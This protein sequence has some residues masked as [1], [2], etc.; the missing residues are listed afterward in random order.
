[1]SSTT[2]RP[3]VT[4]QAVALWAPRLL[5]VLRIVSGLMFMAHG[6]Q[7]LLGFP[8]PAPF[9][10]PA[11]FSELWYAGVLE[12]AGGALLVIGLFTRPVAFVLAGEMA[13]AYWIGHAPH[14]LFPVVNGGDSAVLYCFVFL[15]VA[16]AGAGPWSVDAAM[17]RA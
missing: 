12:L 4:V 3:A 2:I 8:V 15:Y 17:R 10:M 13:V 5:S 11:A 1:M 7:K 14:S 16:V 9:G 6:V